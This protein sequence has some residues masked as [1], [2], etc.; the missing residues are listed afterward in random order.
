M[1]EGRHASVD[2]PFTYLN[3]SA[4][5][6]PQMELMTCHFSEDLSFRPCI[7]AVVAFPATLLDPQEA[8]AAILGVTLVNV[9]FAKDVARMEAMRGLPPGR[10]H[11]VGIA[12]GPAITTPDELEASVLEDPNGRRYDM[13]ILAHVNET[14]VARF[15]ASSVPFTLAEAVSFASSSAAIRSGDLVCIALGEPELAIPLRTGDEVRVVSDRLGTLV[16][17]IG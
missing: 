17:R 15:D 9:F 14:E 1:S 10:S 8:E 6:G 3:S 11:D 7:A 2:L 4:V 12:V 5:V 16:N 13:T